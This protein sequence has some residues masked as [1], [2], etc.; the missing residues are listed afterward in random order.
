MGFKTPGL[1]AKRGQVLIS[2]FRSADDKRRGAGQFG[3]GELQ[4]F[5]NVEAFATRATASR[6]SLSHQVLK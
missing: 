5:L 4:R 3:I 6:M 1:A 2:A